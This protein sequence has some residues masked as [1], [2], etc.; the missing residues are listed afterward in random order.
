MDMEIEVKRKGNNVNI[1]HDG[2]LALHLD[3]SNG[4]Y[5]AVNDH[6]RV[7]A[8]IERISENATKFSDVSLKKMNRSG[9]M[10]KILLK[11]GLNTIHHGL[12]MSVRN[13]D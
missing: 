1:Y 13:T 11:S 6:V 10:T 3:K 8:R 12:N 4:I 7:S 9:K 5:T 2:K